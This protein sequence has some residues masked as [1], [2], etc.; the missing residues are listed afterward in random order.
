MLVQL[1]VFPF[2]L[3]FTLRHQRNVLLEAPASCWR[4]R[5]EAATVAGKPDMPVTL[6]WIEKQVPPRPPSSSFD[7]VPWRRSVYT[8]GFLSAQRLPR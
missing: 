5:H 3:P 6:I 2:A 7:P 1:P 8:A 4:T